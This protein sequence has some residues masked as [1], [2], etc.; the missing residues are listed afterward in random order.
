MCPVCWA[1][2]IA[3]FL[4]LSSGAAV[5]IAGRD[6]I[7]LLLAIAGGALA[8]AHRTGYV[9]VPWLLLSIPLVLLIGRLLMLAVRAHVGS[10]WE[11]SCRIAKL[12]CPNRDKTLN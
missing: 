9:T 3:S 1:A 11:Q 7:I 2:A 6:K 12:A 5:L 4:G 10:T 8:I